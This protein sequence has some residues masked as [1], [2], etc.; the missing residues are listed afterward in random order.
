MEASFAVLDHFLGV[1]LLLFSLFFE[2]VCHPL[3]FFEEE[4]PVCFVALLRFLENIRGLVDGRSLKIFL[5]KVKIDTL[6]LTNAVPKFSDL[7]DEA[8]TF[9]SQLFD[10]GLLLFVL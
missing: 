10:L 4:V 7:M 3:G 9:L 6:F 2:I 5:V 1:A 8:C